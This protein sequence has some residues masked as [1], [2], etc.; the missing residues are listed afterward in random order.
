MHTDLVQGQN[1]AFYLKLTHILT[2]SLYKLGNP[3]YQRGEDKSIVIK[4]GRIDTKSLLNRNLQLSAKLLAE[5]SNHNNE[6]R[7]QT[8]EL[9]N[10]E[11]TG[12][13]ET[14]EKPAGNDNKKG[15]LVIYCSSFLFQNF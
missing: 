6:T 3:T 5:Q 2:V 15:K 1:A 7:P 8:E 9:V 12:S 11:T 4:K 10:L 13:T 14:D